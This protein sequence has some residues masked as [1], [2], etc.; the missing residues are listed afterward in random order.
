MVYG[1]LG[2]YPL[3]IDIQSRIISFWAKLKH[4]SK[5]DTAICIYKILKSL[6]NQMKLNFKW[7]INIKNLICTNGYSSIWESHNEV[8]PN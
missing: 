6:N 8:N 2:A 4:N 7:L 1:E 5:N 3:Y